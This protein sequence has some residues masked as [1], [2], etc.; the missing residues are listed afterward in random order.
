MSGIFKLDWR[1]L[2]KGLVV[3]VFSAV[4]TLVIEM[5]Q[6]GSID[7]KAIGVTG[8]IAGLSYIL[9]NLLTDNEGK[10]GGKI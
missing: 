5:L 10:L 1:D 2:L 7:W 3:T 4:I 6:A 9:K 8:L